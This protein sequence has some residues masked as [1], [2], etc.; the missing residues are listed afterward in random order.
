MKE[1]TKKITTTRWAKF[2]VNRVGKYHFGYNFNNSYIFK[3]TVSPV[4]AKV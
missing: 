2:I 4:D 3:S 1:F